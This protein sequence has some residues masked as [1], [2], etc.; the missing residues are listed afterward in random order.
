MGPP[1]RSNQ[2]AGYRPGLPPRFAFDP[3]SILTYIDK[4][5]DE[6]LK[7]ALKTRGAGSSKFEGSG[8]MYYEEDGIRVWETKDNNARARLLINVLTPRIMAG[9]AGFEP[10]TSGSLH[11]Q[12]C[13]RLAQSLQILRPIL[14]RQRALEISFIKCYGYFRLESIGLIGYQCLLTNSAPFRFWSRGS[15]ELTGTKP[16]NG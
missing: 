10:A 14:T 13:R 5:I 8:P 6:K 12:R 2:G 16:L 4:Y 11:L 15:S 1:T 3:A 9:P 7:N